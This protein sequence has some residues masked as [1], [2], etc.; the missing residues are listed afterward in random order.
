M[1]HLGDLIAVSIGEKNWTYPNLLLGIR[2]MPR[3][4]LYNKFRCYGKINEADMVSRLK[5]S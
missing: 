3:R 2:N 4:L 1:W 5:Y